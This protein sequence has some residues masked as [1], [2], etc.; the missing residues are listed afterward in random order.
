MEGITDHCVKVVIAQILKEVGFIGVH[1]S[2][3]DTLSDV[4]RRAIQ[5]VA[6]AAA[7]NAASASRSETT[8]VDIE[9]P[10]QDM[11]WPV[12]TLIPWCAS[13]DPLPYPQNGVGGSLPKLPL[14]QKPLL[15]QP[16]LDHFI[17]QK[18]QINTMNAFELPRAT[19][20]THPHIPP[21][22]PRFPEKRTY[23]STELFVDDGS[24]PKRVRRKRI[25]ESIKMEGSLTNLHRAKTVPSA[26]ELDDEAALIP[27]AHNYL[28]TDNYEDS[29]QG[30]R[31]AYS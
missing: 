30:L 25:D 16:K 14:A 7:N 17:D 24:D 12:E 11:G 8:Y 23:S 27:P 26:L 10:L 22:L 13:S 21:H 29:L 31:G 28:Q 2:A 20:E 3:V 15:V 9:G 6:E 5:E 18:R 4:V 19:P 1:R